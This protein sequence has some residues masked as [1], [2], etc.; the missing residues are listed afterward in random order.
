MWVHGKVP[1]VF[2]AQ[3]QRW[4][5]QR[6]RTLGGKGFNLENSPLGEGKSQRCITFIA[7]QEAP[8]GKGSDRIFREVGAQEIWFAE[9]GLT[10]VKPKR[11][12]WCWTFLKAPKYKAWVLV[13][14][15]CQKALRGAHPTSSRASHTYQRVP[16]LL[17]KD[18]QIL[19]CDSPKWL[20]HQ[21]IFLITGWN[22]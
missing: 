21:F 15:Q 12:W 2:M 14:A 16:A 22:S 13:P 5:A 19:C 9:W 4:W 7:T 10:P 8:L 6:I 3:G 17:W 18:I 20:K 11:G 1:S